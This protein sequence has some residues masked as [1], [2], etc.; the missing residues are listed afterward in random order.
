MMKKTFDWKEPFQKLAALPIFKSHFAW[1]PLNALVLLAGIGLTAALVYRQGNLSDDLVIATGV[2]AIFMILSLFMGRRWEQILSGVVLIG[3]ALKLVLPDEK[4]LL[5]VTGIALAAILS[6]VVQVAS[7]WEKAILL[8][9]GR[10][11]GLRGPGL[12]LILPFVDRIEAFVD[13]RVRATDFRAERILTLDTVPVYVDAIS[14]W[15]V[16][17][18]E[19]AVLEVADYAHAVIL[20]AQAALRD[21]VGKHELNDLLSEREKL[22]DEIQHRVDEKTN[23]WGITIQSI[24]I[25][26]VV[27]PESLEEA[28]SKR[29]QAERERQARI[30]LSTTESE[31]AEKFAA[32]ADQYRDDPTALHLRAMNMI[33]EGIRQKGSMIIVPS[34]AVET[35]G[36]G[37]VSGIS[38]LAKG[39]EAKTPEKKEEE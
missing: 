4:I 11:S 37:T 2:A 18:A 31:I 36:L 17:S 26:D 3:I 23:A 24:E 6:C 27:I 13:Q 25:T 10:Y 21:A 22:C 5:L 14:F 28:M 29:A 30:I 32:A 8:R 12:F 34:S 35:M 7:Q 33:Y 1:G 20:S 19:K 16:W 39:E 9:L 15:L 38:A